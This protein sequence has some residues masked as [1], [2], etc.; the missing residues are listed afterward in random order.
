MINTFKTYTLLEIKF[1]ALLITAHVLYPKLFSKP[2]VNFTQENFVILNDENGYTGKHK[3]DTFCNY[4]LD[5]IGFKDP[6]FEDPSKKF[7]VST[8]KFYK[9]FQVDAN[10]QLTVDKLLIY[11]F[12]LL[13][14]NIIKEIV[15]N[16]APLILPSASVTFEKIYDSKRALLQNY[17]M[18]TNTEDPHAILYS[19]IDDEK[20]D[21]LSIFCHFVAK[22]PI[23]LDHSKE[24][25]MFINAYSVTTFFKLINISYFHY[26][27]NSRI[28][29]DDP[30]SSFIAFPFS[31]AQFMV[32][33]VKI[34][35]FEPS[36]IFKFGN[37]L[38]SVAKNLDNRS[39][40]ESDTF[41]RNINLDNLL[42]PWKKPDLNNQQLELIS[43]EIINELTANNIDASTSS[44]LIPKTSEFPASINLPKLFRQINMKK[45]S[46]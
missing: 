40:T 1:L 3:L 29:D 36:E 6:S 45:K 23:I 2:N 10:S 32:G 30:Y 22:L 13:E 21:L 35:N 31:A 11:L 33:H 34:Y 26:L 44:F 41:T 38:T 16:P 17:Q 4:V 46:Y 39:H 12:Y 37:A 19:T 9:A 20:T 18:P 25:R 42:N 27:H 8:Q 24:Q 5:K 43:S 14:P 28:A 7:N 15:T